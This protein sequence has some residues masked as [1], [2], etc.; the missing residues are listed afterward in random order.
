VEQENR[1][2]AAG[3]NRGV[4]ELGVGDGFVLFCNP[5]VRI[6]CERALRDAGGYLMRNDR[7]AC[8]IPWMVNERGDPNHPCRRFYTPATLAGARVPWPGGRWPEFMAR[9]FYADDSRDAPFEVD[10]GCGGAMLFRRCLFPS[11]LHF[12]ERFFMYLEDADICAQTWAA[13]WSVVCYPQWVVIHAAKKRSHRNLG[14]FARHVLSMARFMAKYRGLPD[15][16]HLVD[17]PRGRG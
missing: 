4:S 3:L 17:S 6:P 12:D 14:H 16:R 7:V 9:H 1:G 2:Y 8:L 15:R 11:P 5:D 13:G 10:W